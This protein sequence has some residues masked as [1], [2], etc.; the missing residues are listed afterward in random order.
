MQLVRGSI[1]TENQS[2]T[3]EKIP[4]HFHQMMAYRQ[5]KSSPFRFDEYL[6]RFKR[7]KQEIMRSM[8][9][10]ICLIFIYALQSNNNHR[11]PDSSTQTHTH[12]ICAE[13]TYIQAIIKIQFIFWYVLLVNFKLKCSIF[14]SLV[15]F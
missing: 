9:V 1:S 4:H 8:P 13:I 10:P 3:N 15:Q 11:R 2:K 14:L 5:P 12:S 6:I 7:Y